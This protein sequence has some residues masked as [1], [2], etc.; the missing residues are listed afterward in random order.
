MS[1][2]H[3]RKWMLAFKKSFCQ[4]KMSVPVN[5]VYTHFI[6]RFLMQYPFPVCLS[7]HQSVHLSLSLHG[8]STKNP[9]SC[10]RKPWICHLSNILFDS[11]IKLKCKLSALKYP[12]I[13]KHVN[14]NTMMW[15]LKTRKKLQ[16]WTIKE[17]Q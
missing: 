6:I 8:Q 4:I 15:K 3:H 9:T 14:K 16:S 13:L 2:T 17:K 1:V 7:V 12:F 10:I 11:N 5:S